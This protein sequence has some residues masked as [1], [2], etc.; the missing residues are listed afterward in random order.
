M[1]FDLEAL[2]LPLDDLEALILAFS[3]DEI[4]EVVRNL[5]IDKSLG[6]DGFNTDFMKKCWEV[7]I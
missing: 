5:K 6:L 1:H 4:D 3:N 7:K 2:L